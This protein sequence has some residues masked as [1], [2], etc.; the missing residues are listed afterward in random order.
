MK[1][2]FSV[3]IIIIFLSACKQAKV[4]QNIKD[5]TNS[6]TF[7]F[8][9]Q[10]HRGTRGLMPENT[11]TAF[12]RALE[13][14]VNTLEMDVVVTRD[15]QLLVSH[16]P[17]F[18][19]EICLDSLGETIKDSIPI[20]I[21]KQTY[22]QTQKYDCGSLGNPNFPEQ[23]RQYATKPL[24][25][26]VLQMAE[27]YAKLNNQKISYN[28][29]IKSLPAGDNIYHPKPEKFVEMLIALLENHSI[30]KDK[31]ILQSF[32]FRVLQYVHKT[33]PKYRLAALV[34]KDDVQTNL[35]QLGF[36]PEIY[37]PL[38]TLLTAQ[39]VDEIHQKGMKLVPWTV[40]ETER[41]KELLIWGVDGIITDY[42]DK[43]IRFQQK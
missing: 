1:N 36:T 12:R 10:G 31:L 14:G 40:N 34:Y 17:W 38:H 20:N 23:N 7:T 16:E 37:S 35:N 13:I 4:V 8:D 22:L 26:D 25:I 42:P 41:M 30:S 21:Y 19:R 43:A 6:E 33:Y 18:N 24:L 3:I 29:E 32:D 15:N 5:T 9:L 27:S 11:L 39:V 28:I 2:L